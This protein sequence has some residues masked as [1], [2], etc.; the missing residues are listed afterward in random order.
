VAWVVGVG[1]AAP[2]AA[3][4]PQDLEGELRRIGVYPRAPLQATDVGVGTFRLEAGPGGDLRT[5]PGSARLTVPAGALH[6]VARE[7]FA[8]SYSELP[9]GPLFGPVDWRLGETSPPPLESLLAP[10]E[11]TVPSEMDLLSQNLQ[12]L[13]LALYGD[14]S[15]MES[16]SGDLE[17]EAAYLES[18]Y[19]TASEDD[20]CTRWVD[21]EPVF[22]PGCREPCVGTDCPTTTYV[23]YPQIWYDV[24]A[25]VEARTG[26]VFSDAC[27]LVSPDTCADIAWV[28]SAVAPPLSPDA[29]PA[30]RWLWDA[31]GAYDVVHASGSLAPYAG[32]LLFALGPEAHRTGPG[33]RGMVFLLVPPVGAVAPPYGTVL[34]RS[35]LPDGVLAGAYGSEQST[36]ICSGPDADGDGMP[37]ACDNC[38][39]WPNGI[40]RPLGGLQEDTDGDGYGNACDCDFDQDGACGSAADYYE[41][42]KSLFTGE[43]THT[44]MNGDG[45]LDWIDFLY[46]V[47]GYHRGAPGPSGL[48]GP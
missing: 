43:G 39:A 10:V 12:D 14:G 6:A 1:L 18:V 25:A 37:D 34:L 2:A 19:G 15:A 28:G 32:W 31:G 9:L 21:G 17:D 46:F 7:P 47:A 11:A 13:L 26:L 8:V 23:P 4:F 16:G 3:D 42:M 48:V 38:S 35:V 33:G 30:G 20:T 41:L 45:R 27:G 22:L 5:S 44:D 24:A 29:D 36:S 40:D